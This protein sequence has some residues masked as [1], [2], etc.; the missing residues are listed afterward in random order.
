[1]KL[2]RIS[3]TAVFLFFTIVILAYA[4]SDKI[5]RPPSQQYSTPQQTTP[6]SPKVTPET[7]KEPKP[8]ISSP[9]SLNIINFSASSTTI[10]Y[11]EEVTLRWT[12]S[13]NNL[14]GL[15]LEITPDIGQIPLS[16]T[17]YRN[18]SFT[19]EGSKTIKPSKT[20]KYILRILAIDPVRLDIDQAGNI[21]RRTLEAK[22]ALII[23]VKKPKIENVKPLVDQK[24]MKIK[25]LAKNTGDGDFTSSPIQ[26]EYNVINSLSGPSLASGK[27][28]TTNLNIRAGEQVQLGE[29]TLPDR[30]K[31]L[32]GDAILIGVG[33]NPIYRVPLERDSDT[34]EHQWERKRLTI[35]ND[36]IS[37]FGGLL[38]GSIRLNNFDGS[39]SAT[40]T[41]NPYKANDSYVEIMGRRET[42]SIPRFDYTKGIYDYRGF[43]KNLNASFSGRDLFSVEDGK[44]KLRISFETSGTEI[45]G[46][47]YTWGVWHDA[48]APDYNFTKFDITV[49]FFPGLRNGKI[50]Y[51]DV[52]VVPDVRGTFVGAWDT[53]LSEKLERDID[54]KIKNELIKRIKSK[55]MEEAIRTIIENK[56]EELITHNRFFNIYR[57]VNVIGEG[58]NI[59][60]EYIEN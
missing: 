39:S 40:L 8:G 25:F 52:Q 58:G 50:T 11:G 30:G 27:F 19:I 34:Y 3:T 14:S 43:I 10:N 2:L 16:R 1:M 20:E 33:I 53:L 46:Y 38:T 31:A 54:E 18:E 60:I 47:E 24:T 42:F 12:I 21:H 49:Y 44:I 6:I 59:V 13:G 45:R 51:K 5:Q 15:K 56:I 26:V 23:S 4:Q 28:T 48:T 29:T 41:H 17:D 9:Y 57:V 55:L 36:L 37:I 7:K 35:N 22:N 32:S